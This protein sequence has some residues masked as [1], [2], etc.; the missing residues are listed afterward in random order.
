VVVAGRRA[1][2]AAIEHKLAEVHHRL[3]DW[4]LAEAHLAAADQL[5]AADDAGR[6]A[7]VA[8]DRAVLAYRRGAMAEA[9]VRRRRCRWPRRPW[10][11]AANW[12]IS[13]VSRRCTPTWPTCCMR[14][15]SGRPPSLTS[16]RRRGASP[17]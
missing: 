3:G 12:G 8:A 16:R 14:P 17:P 15:A 10:R 5:L 4:A 6:R 11:S 13:T 9:A 1:G 7:R 2:V